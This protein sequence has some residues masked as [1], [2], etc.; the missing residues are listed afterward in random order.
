MEWI[1]LRPFFQSRSTFLLNR[2]AVGS[3]KLYR[4]TLVS[5]WGPSCCALYAAVGGWTTGL[6]GDHWY[7]HILWKWVLKSGNVPCLCN[8]KSTGGLT[9]VLLDP[10]PRGLFDTTGFRTWSPEGPQR[11]AA[12][13]LEGSSGASPPPPKDQRDQ[14]PRFCLLRK[15]TW[16][17]AGPG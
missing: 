1:S 6:W 7:T 9:L 16:L 8:A 17:W 4:E 12:L 13:G 3:N 15:W 11:D 14:G 10:W 2:W 5:P